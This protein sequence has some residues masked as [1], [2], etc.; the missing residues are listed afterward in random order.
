M[1]VV[2]LHEPEE[3]EQPWLSTSREYV[4]LSVEEHHTGVAGYRIE[5]D[6]SQG[7][8][9]FRAP[10]FKIIDP[11]VPSCWIA[12]RLQGATVELAPPVFA[13]AG[14]WEDYYNGDPRAVA[15]YRRIRDQ[16]MIESTAGTVPE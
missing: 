3:A 1:R 9:L 16:L 7:P 8:A 2:L 13:R 14:F 15:E 5:S 10:R 6:R 12:H 11:S 4:V